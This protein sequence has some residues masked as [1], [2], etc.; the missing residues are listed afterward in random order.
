[1]NRM[2]VSNVLKNRVMLAPMGQPMI[3][4]RG[5]R[6]RAICMDEPTATPMAKSILSFMAT[7][8][9]VTC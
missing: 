5:V 9:A 2:A 6:R 4:I 1:M 8:T 3:T 7:V